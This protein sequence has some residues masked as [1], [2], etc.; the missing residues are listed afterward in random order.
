MG[1]RPLLAAAAEFGGMP[2]LAAAW[3]GWQMD[4]LGVR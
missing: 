1:Q 4:E 2:T 3:N